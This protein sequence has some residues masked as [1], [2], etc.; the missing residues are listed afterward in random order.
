MSISVVIYMYYNNFNSLISLFITGVIHVLKQFA[1]PFTK[2][3]DNLNE[4]YQKIY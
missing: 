3:I 4:I 1:R 2:K